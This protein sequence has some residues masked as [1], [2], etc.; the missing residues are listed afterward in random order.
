MNY[1]AVALF[2]Y[3]SWLTM[4]DS[5]DSVDHLSTYC[6][7][8]CIKYWELDKILKVFIAISVIVWWY[9]FWYLFLEVVSISNALTMN[10]VLNRHRYRYLYAPCLALDDS[11]KMRFK[12]PFTKGF[13][14]NWLDFIIN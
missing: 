8:L 9:N 3:L 6:I 5:L 11:I 14:Q 10:E 1:A 13:V 4:H 12:N 2:L 7:E